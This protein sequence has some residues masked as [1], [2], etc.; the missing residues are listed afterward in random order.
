MTK[1]SMKLKKNYLL[2]Y[3]FVILNYNVIKEYY[4]QLQDFY[5][6]IIY[7]YSLYV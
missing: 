4:Y 2:F 5:D 7:S 6:K 3:Y 1:Q